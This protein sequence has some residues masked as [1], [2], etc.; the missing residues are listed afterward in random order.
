LKGGDLSPLFTINSKTVLKSCSM[1][2]LWLTFLLL[3]SIQL[4]ADPWGK[5]AD[6]CH[7]EAV[8][9]SPQV[10]QVIP[11]VDWITS[12]MIHFH[13]EIISPADGPRSHFMPSSS[14]Y[15]LDAIARYGFF[16]GFLLGCDRLMRENSDDWVYNKV[17]SPSGVCL[18]YDPVR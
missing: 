17:Q 3:W 8:A 1:L 9:S 5:D 4:A 10:A 12:K 11:G 14:Q 13:Q 7:K 16:R 18:N 15:T 2:R 6:L